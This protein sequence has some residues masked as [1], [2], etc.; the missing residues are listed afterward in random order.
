MEDRR[1]LKDERVQS[2]VIVILLLLLVLLVMG[3]TYAAFSYNKAGTVPNVITTG[4]MT[5]TYTEGESGITLTNAVPLTDSVG[6]TLS[7]D[8]EMFDFNV[9]TKVSSGQSISYEI[10]AVKQPNSTISN[11]KVKLYLESGTTPN[12]Y[13]TVVLEP[14]VYTPLT[15]DDSFGAKS[16]EMV[17]ATKVNTTTET[18]YYRLR[19]WLASD[20]ELT[21][22]A[23]V[24]TVKVN[25]YGRD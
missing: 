15:A 14:T 1:D 21:N 2:V 3:I 6:K 10:T 19:M 4:T 12:I 8:E 16:G 13:D 7:K 5:M 24:F 25:A 17:L 11:D 20:Y 23:E 22:T 18:N 9:Y